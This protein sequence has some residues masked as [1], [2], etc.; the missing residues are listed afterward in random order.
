MNSEKLAVTRETSAD[1]L[2]ART[3]LCANLDHLG[4]GKAYLLHYDGEAGHF[5][6]VTYGDAPFHADGYQ[7]LPLHLFPKNCGILAE[8]KHFTS[9]KPLARLCGALGMNTAAFESA[10]SVPVGENPIQALLLFFSPE[11]VLWTEKLRRSLGNLALLYE[12]QL[13]GQPDRNVIVHQGQ[14]FKQLHEHSPDAILVVH[15]D[16][17]ILESNSSAAKLLRTDA[18]RLPG[19]SLCDF[20]PDEKSAEIVRNQLRRVVEAGALFFETSLHCHDHAVVHVDVYNSLL[21]IGGEPAVKMVLRDITEHKQALATIKRV[22][23]QVVN[24]LENTTDAYLSINNRFE[25]IYFNG[26][27]ERLFGR[28]R[29]KVIGKPLWDTIPDLATDFYKPIQDGI[30]KRRQGSHKGY[31]REKKRWLEIHLYPN[32]D[33]LS[34]YL[35]DITGREEAETEMRTLAEFPE[36]HPEP[37]LRIAR[38][39]DIAYANK[40]G[41]PLLTSWGRHVG[42]PLPDDMLTLH[43]EILNTRRFHEF[44]R[45]YDGSIFSILLVPAPDLGHCYLYARDITRRVRAEQELVRHRD[46]LEEL[47]RTRTEALAIARDQAN[48]ANRAKSAFLASMSHELR[49]PLNAII[50]Y[51][52]LLAEEAGEANLPRF[53]EDLEQI[54]NAGNFLLELINDILDLSKIEAGKIELHLA[55]FNLFELVKELQATLAPVARKGGNTLSIE[56]SPDIGEMYSDRTRVRQCLLNLLSN[57]CKFTENG[58]IRLI[59]HRDRSSQTHWLRFEVEDTGIG[60]TAEQVGRVFQAFTQADPSTA[61]R[62]G[63]TGLGLAIS[64]RLC[65]LMGGDISVTST[66]GKGSVFTMRLPAKAPAPIPRR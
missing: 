58:T 49:T 26:R 4:S 45:E 22:N 15:L 34:V 30:Q 2:A 29:K 5:R 50:G 63:G 43:H 39:G 38:N 64:R 57:A 27:A 65:R 18:P 61:S 24:I 13:A 66:F 7:I 20:L 23:S 55:E 56:C 17:T 37:V 6:V 12:C 3:Y 52:E 1:S 11:P 36:H 46:K 40:A 41:Q 10:I 25:I 8:P 42:D 44:E 28:K 54:Y 21:T 53:K 16:L 9:L 51:A 60:M 59:V 14:R 33:G 47:V 32:P 48:Q 62:Y 35:R 31:Y 19:K